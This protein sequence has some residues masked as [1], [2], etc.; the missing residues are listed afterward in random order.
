[1]ICATGEFAIQLEVW[2]DL[3][4]REQKEKFLKFPEPQKMEEVAEKAYRAM[5]RMQ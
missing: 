3:L 4:E 1:M 2:Y 5:K